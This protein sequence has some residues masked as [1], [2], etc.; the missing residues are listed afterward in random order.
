[1]NNKYRA[2]CDGG[3]FTRKDGSTAPSYF[4]YK[5]FKQN[6]SKPLY[7]ISRFYLRSL[8]PTQYQQAKKRIGWLGETINIV[9]DTSLFVPANCSIFNTN[10]KETN[11][12]A[13]IA[14]LYY[15]LSKLFSLI[16]PSSQ[17]EMFSDSQL[18][19]NQVNGLWMC[20]QDHLKP[21][22]AVTNQLKNQMDITLTWTS[23]DNIV[24]ILGH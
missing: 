5:I 14:A 19:V 17:I 8:I 7:A 22:L 9:N 23:R 10:N 4:S 18:I 15:C 13:E 20:K 6:N 3:C 12:I 24:R 21:W 16:Q 2:F 11:N 1:M